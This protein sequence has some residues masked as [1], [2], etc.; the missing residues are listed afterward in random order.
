M[1]LN[2][3]CYDWLR[4]PK[5]EWSF[6]TDR[7]IFFCSLDK[8]WNL[9]YRIAIYGSMIYTAPYVMLLMQ[10]NPLRVQV[11][12]GWALESRLFWALL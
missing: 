10:A 1:N 6:T 2:Y 12:G 8:K 4:V 7:D 3:S 9:G 11:G 5:I